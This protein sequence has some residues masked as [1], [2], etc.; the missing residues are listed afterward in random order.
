MSRY[1]RQTC[2]VGV[3]QSGQEAIRSAGVLVVGAGGLAAP[4]LQYL[5]AAGV[6]RICIVDGDVVAL[7]NLHRQTLFREADI[8][9][10]KVDVAVQ[11]LRALNST[12]AI[13]GI[14]APLDPLNAAPLVGQSTLV[15]DCADSFAVSYILSDTCKSLG[16]PLISASVL[17]HAGYV[18]GFCQGAPSLRAV[19][20][21]LPD[22]AA[23]C[24][25]A[26]VMGPVVGMIGAAQAQM[27]LAYL[28]GQ[29]PSP[30]GQLIRFDMQNFRSSSFRFDAAA[31]PVADLRFIAACEIGDTDFIIELR[32]RDEAAT[33]VAAT[34]QRLSVAQFADQRP[35]PALGQ[36]AVFAC[37]SGLRAWQAA[38]HLR[39]YWDGDITLIATGD[40]PSTE[41][42]PI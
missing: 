40:T 15:L 23:T 39:S 41:R 6:G 11:S 26:G 22:R 17:E 33:P 12:C 16:V 13:E 18:G 3:G 21:D 34:A 5:V 2:L 27:A 35:M 20:P 7:S 28:I 30:L 25:T 38:T 9:K 1:A 32:D 24:A 42:L 14:D 4:V 37:R 29:Q 10:A 31:D 36:R 19:F 8:G